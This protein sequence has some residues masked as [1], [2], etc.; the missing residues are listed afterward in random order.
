MK[1]TILL[2]LQVFPNYSTDSNIPGLP[3]STWACKNPGN[4]HSVLITNRK[5]N[6]VKNH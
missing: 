2:I 4:P 6:K 1:D 5:L 3:V